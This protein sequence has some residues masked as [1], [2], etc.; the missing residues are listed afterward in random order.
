ML[1]PFFRWRVLQVNICANIAV[2]FDVAVLVLKRLLAP[3]LVGRVCS[4]TIYAPEQGY[5]PYHASAMDGYAININDMHLD[6]VHDNS[7]IKRFQ[8]VNR[9]YAGSTAA[10]TTPASK[11]KQ[12]MNIL[13][14]DN[15][16]KAIYVTMGAVIP[17]PTYNTVIPLE[18]VNEYISNQV[19]AID[20]NVLQNAEPNI[21]CGSAT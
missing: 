1:F 10:S 6:L 13:I 5:P 20:L 14:N 7:T 12:A 8:I 17:Y 21:T 18:Q 4:E 15:L 3:C 19:I 9:I 2:V 11:V 16:P